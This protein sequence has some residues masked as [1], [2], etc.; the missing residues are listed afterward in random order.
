MGTVPWQCSRPNGPVSFSTFVWTYLNIK[1]HFT[2]K[3][4]VQVNL[5]TASFPKKMQVFQITSGIS[6]GWVA[7]AWHQGSSLQN[8]LGCLPQWKQGKPCQGLHFS[9]NLEVGIIRY[10]NQIQLRPLGH[11]EDCRLGRS[12]SCSST[13]S[14]R[15]TRCPTFKPWHS[16]VAWMGPLDI[17]CQA[18]RTPKPRVWLLHQIVQVWCLSCYQANYLHSLIWARLTLIL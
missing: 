18:G 15:W 1:V 10:H 3:Y 9:F 16:S 7:I 13:I 17:C 11:L 6:P 4:A 12:P 14:K 5:L 2:L 8:V